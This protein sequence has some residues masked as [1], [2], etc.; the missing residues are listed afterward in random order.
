MDTQTGRIVYLTAEQQSQALAQLRAFEAG[1]LKTQPRFLPLEGDRITQGRY[2][3]RTKGRK[4]QRRRVR[5]YR[6]FCN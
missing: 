1:L 4:A 3:S 2:R 6:E 5:T